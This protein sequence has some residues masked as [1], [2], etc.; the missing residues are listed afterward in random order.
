MMHEHG[1]SDRRVVPAKPPNKGVDEPLQGTARPKP[2]EAVE[3]RHL[4]KSNP[5]QR[6]ML[7]TQRRV[8]MPP[9]LE[10]IRQAARRERKMPFTV[11]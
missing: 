6:T 4:A 2:A 5:H 1:K 8:G 10:R 9:Q 7:R 11:L 3:G